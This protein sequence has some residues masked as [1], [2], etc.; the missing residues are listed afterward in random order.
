MFP[1]KSTA[2]LAC[3]APACPKPAAS[4]AWGF[5]K[6]KSN[7]NFSH[8]VKNNQRHVCTDDRQAREVRGANGC[9]PGEDIPGTLEECLVSPR[10]DVLFTTSFWA[11]AAQYFAAQIGSPGF[12][13]PYRTMRAACGGQRVGGGGGR[14][15]RRTHP[16]P[17]VVVGGWR[18]T[19][20]FLP[21]RLQHAGAP[22]GSFRVGLIP[23]LPQGDWGRVPPQ[24]RRMAPH[25][26]T[27]QVG[28]GLAG[29]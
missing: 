22:L 25:V 12:T 26:L 17:S 2:L 27:L 1:P 4:G 9:A 19:R 5:L 11:R 29:L 10:A 14:G 3:Q 13:T 6:N 18:R 16:K 24:L 23:R 8:L 7:A 15:S 20:G 28:A 21:Q